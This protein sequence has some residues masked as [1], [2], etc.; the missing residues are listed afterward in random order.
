MKIYPPKLISSVSKS[1]LLCSDI[2]RLEKRTHEG[3]CFKAYIRKGGQ[4]SFVKS[5]DNVPDMQVCVFPEAA[6]HILPDFGNNQFGNFIR[7]AGNREDRFLGFAM[8]EDVSKLLQLP[9][10]SHF[11]GVLIIEKAAFRIE[12][13]KLTGGSGVPMA[14]DFLPTA[15][16]LSF[17]LTFPYIWARLSAEMIQVGLQTEKGKNK[18]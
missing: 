15:E 11:L 5:F 13:L 1:A 3:G 17:F 4:R 14:I 10:R 18:A 7:S 2:C 12:K 9:N 16:I 6:L 8:N